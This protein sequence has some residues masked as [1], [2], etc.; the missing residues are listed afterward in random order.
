LA[1][2]LFLSSPGD[3]SIAP[4]LE[5]VDGVVP[6][7]VNALVPEF[8]AATQSAP[9]TAVFY[10]GVGSS[11]NAASLASSVGGQTLETILAENGQVMPVWSPTNLV[12]QQSWIAASISYAQQASGTVYA[13]VG[14]TVRANAIW[15]NY[16]LP[17]LYNNPNVT[18]III[19]NVSTGVS[20]TFP[21]GGP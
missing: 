2:K 18:Q 14:N 11:A 5:A 3:Q 19:K 12:A 10:S 17:A 21:T 9:G 20:T 15:Q 6:A 16:E 4:S 7:Q 1:A 8:Q 13:F